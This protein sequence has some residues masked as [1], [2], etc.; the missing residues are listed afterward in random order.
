MEFKELGRT[1]EKIPVLGIG[2]WKMGLNPK[3]E[4]GA[5]RF[6]ISH[7]I[8]FIDTAEIY[9]TEHIVA[10][11]IKDEK[12]VFIATKV[13]PHHFSYENVIKACDNSLKILGVKQIDLYQLHW[14][15]PIIPIKETMRAMEKLVDDGKIRYIGI[16]NFSVEQT[17]EAQDALKKHEIVSNQVEY[18]L[19]VRDIEKDLLPFCEK[20]KITIIAYSPFA[21][22]HL[23]HHR[24]AVEALQVIADKYKKS[25]ASVALKF[26]ISREPV[27]AI[28]KASDKRHVEEIAEAVG[29]KLKKEDLKELDNSLMKSN[30]YSLRRTLGI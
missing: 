28:P 21:R 12:D 30:V 7:G 20:E 11:A 15:N 2:T 10:E 25:V 29:W 19:L 14:P 9:G 22:G 17:K 6:G 18:S 26:L 3:Q 23:F 8:R 1:G 4:I 13:S 27:V 24:K 16:S 5:L